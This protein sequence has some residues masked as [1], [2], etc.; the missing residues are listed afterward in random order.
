MATAEVTTAARTV[1]TPPWTIKSRTSSRTT[2]ASTRTR[3]VTVGAT[4][5]RTTTG[6]E[7]PYDYGTSFRDRRG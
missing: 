6:D 5:K 1:A 4:T 7:C 3:T 2:H